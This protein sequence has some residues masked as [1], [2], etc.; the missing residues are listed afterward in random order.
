MNQDLILNVVSLLIALLS[1]IISVIALKISQRVLVYSSRDYL[2]TLEWSIDDNSDVLTI[3]N[4]SYQLFTILQV[5]FLKIESVGFEL[6]DS[7]QYIQVPFVVG[8]LLKGDLMAEKRITVGHH[9]S[10]AYAYLKPYSPKLVQEFKD[11]APITQDFGSDYMYIP[12]L[13]SLCYLI[14][15]Y[16]IDRFQETKQIYLKKQHIH[17]L[18]FQQAMIGEDEFQTKLK[19]SSIPNFDNVSQLLDYSLA[20]HCYKYS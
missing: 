6:N 8:S 16:Y 5:A 15:I 9:N 14:E 3:Q 13:Q 1:L 7:D 18:G 4:K 12:S 19:Q 17:G 11:I 10:F 20:K 2:P